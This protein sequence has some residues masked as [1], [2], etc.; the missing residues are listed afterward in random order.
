M[1]DEKTKPKA[2]SPWSRF[3]KESLSPAFLPQ[4]RVVSSLR[5]WIAIGLFCFRSG[6]SLVLPEQCNAR[7]VE[8]S[9]LIG[10]RVTKAQVESLIK[11]MAAIVADVGDPVTSPLQRFNFPVS[12]S[13]LTTSI[14]F[15]A[16]SNT[17]QSTQNFSYLLQFH[18]WNSPSVSV[19]SPSTLYSNKTI[20]ICIWHT[21]L[22]HPPCKHKNNW[23]KIVF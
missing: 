18:L 7:D 11:G 2:D 20:T 4:A 12:Y 23:W 3:A 22:C 16:T 17:S 14:L 5:K 13:N 1:Y 21:N 8:N 19:R 6:K 10:H 15:L 9:K